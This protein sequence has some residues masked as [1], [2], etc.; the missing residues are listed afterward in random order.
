MFIATTMSPSGA[1]RRGGNVYRFEFALSLRLSEWRLQCA[2]LQSI[3]VALLRSEEA[4]LND[5]FARGSKG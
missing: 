2:G 5:H 3:N 1:I 4:S